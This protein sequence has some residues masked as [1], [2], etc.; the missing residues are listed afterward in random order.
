MEEKERF[1]PRCVAKKNPRKV[2]C[3]LYCEDFFCHLRHYNSLRQTAML[4][5]CLLKAINKEVLK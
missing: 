1:F 3:C 5:H 2:P 4:N